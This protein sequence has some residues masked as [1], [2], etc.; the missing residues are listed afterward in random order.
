MLAFFA[1]FKLINKND[2]EKYL[3]NLARPKS[4]FSQSLLGIILLEEFGIDSFCFQLFWNENNKLCML[5][6]DIWFVVN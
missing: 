3:N 6:T 4:Y 5:V 1:E 2:F